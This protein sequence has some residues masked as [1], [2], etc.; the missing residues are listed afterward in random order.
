[1][2]KMTSEKNSSVPQTLNLGYNGSFHRARLQGAEGE[3]SSSS[4]EEA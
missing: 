4:K 2:K 3:G 1:M